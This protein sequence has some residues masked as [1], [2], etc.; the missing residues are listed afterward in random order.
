MDLQITYEK[1]MVGMS[2]DE[3][4]D[5]AKPVTAS[6]TGNTRKSIR[7]RSKSPSAGG[8][9]MS[10]RSLNSIT[11]PTKKIN[12]FETYSSPAQIL[13]LHVFARGLDPRNSPPVIETLFSGQ[14]PPTLQ[15]VSLPGQLISTSTDLIDF[16]ILPQL[17]SAH[18][19][20]LLENNSEKPVDISIDLSANYLAAN[21]VNVFAVSPMGCRLNIGEKTLFEM[22]I[23]GNC[24]P[25]V[26]MDTMTVVAREVVK[27]AAAGRK[28]SMASRILNKYKK[29]P[30][31]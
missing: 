7:S 29:K 12:K 23:S 30:V 24:G 31:S 22:K 25:I 14:F 3:M 26:F 11:S 8:S 27:D 21:Y 28:G 19:F 15:L 5:V 4:F 18:R 2:L 10:K 16:G 17:A 13:P 1:S 9:R 20:F 6:S